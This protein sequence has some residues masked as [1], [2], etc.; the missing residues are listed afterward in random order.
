MRKYLFFI[1]IGVFFSEIHTV[2]QTIQEHGSSKVKIGIAAFTFRKFDIDSTLKMYKIADVKYMSVKDFH[3]PLNSTIEEM[4]IFKQKCAANDVI[5]YALGPIYMKTME[6][7]DEAFDYAIRFGGNLLVGVPNYELLPYI[8]QK[9]KETGIRLAIHTHGPDM[10]LYP[11][12]K[13]AYENIKD[14]DSRIGICIDLGHTVRLDINSAEDLLIYKDRIFDIHIKDETLAAEEGT[15]CEMGRGVMDFKPILDA[16]KAIEYRGV[17]SLEFEK[18]PEYPF[19][20]VLESIG[21]LRGALD[22]VFR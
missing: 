4:E 20:G 6:E 2:A 13:D 12:A 16:I 9:V 10:Q 14:L 7:A 1:I 11:D 19:F 3:L 21:Y 5:P 17:V 22:I 18:D 8:E 15:T